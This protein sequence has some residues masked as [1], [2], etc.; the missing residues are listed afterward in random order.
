MPDRIPI[1]RSI[2]NRHSSLERYPLVV[3]ATLVQNPANLG[4]LCRTVEAFCLEKLV[5]ADLSLAQNPLFK[6]LA[7]SSQHWQPLDACSVS[8]LPEWLQQ[9]QQNGYAV[10]GLTVDAAA[11]ELTRFAFPQRALLLL[12]QE[13]T[14]IPTALLSNCNYNITIPQFGMVESLNVQTAAAIAIYEYVRQYRET[15]IPLL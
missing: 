11:V 13:L 15:D 2:R 9:Q 10:I 5:L 4:G 6:N 1:Q 14:G 3:C 8:A 7:A 12:G